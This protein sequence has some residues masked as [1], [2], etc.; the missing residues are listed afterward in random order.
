VNL[1]VN[2][3][4]MISGCMVQLLKKMYRCLNLNTVKPV[5]LTTFIR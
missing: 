4:L 5:K 1:L 2:K 3:R